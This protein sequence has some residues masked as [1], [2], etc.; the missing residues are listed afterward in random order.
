MPV[1]VARCMAAMDALGKRVEVAT[2][3]IAENAAKIIQVDAA[4]RAP[5]GV[6][7]NST[8]ASGDLAAS[9]HIAGPTG[10]GGIYVSTVGP[11]MIYSA[12]REFGGTLNAHNPSGYMT[13]TKFGMVYQKATVW[14]HEEPYMRPAEIAM[15]VPIQT[16]AET[17]LAIALE[18]G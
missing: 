4:M 12:Q 5:R 8:N 1:D 17:T 7:G 13:F 16:M 6:S 18:G 15:L 14:Q 10:G 9:I 2:Y 3:M 11:H